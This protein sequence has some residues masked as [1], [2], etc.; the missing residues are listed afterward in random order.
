ME[1]D[2]SD[3]P[4][5]KPH[6]VNTIGTGVQSIYTAS[7]GG[8]LVSEP[9]LSHIP[10]PV[11]NCLFEPNDRN[12]LWAEEDCDMPIVLSILLAA[13][14]LDEDRL[15]TEFPAALAPDENGQPKI[16]HF[17]HKVCDRSERYAPCRPFLPARQE[18][19]APG[20]ATVAGRG[21]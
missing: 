21:P 19:V 18:A 3:S 15:N 7:H 6:L 2:L 14:Q 9:A 11:R 8:L 1:I 10:M 16:H 17:A 20:A 4:W 13:G 5:G 12:S